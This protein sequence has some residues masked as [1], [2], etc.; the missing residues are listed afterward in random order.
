MDRKQI[1][2]DAKDAIRGSNWVMFSVAQ[3]IWGF[4]LGLIMVVFGILFGVVGGVADAIGIPIV[5]GILYFVI[6]VFGLILML[7]FIGTI[8][9]ASF[10][11]AL[12]LWSGMS[13]DLFQISKYTK[14]IVTNA[15]CM[16]SLIWRMYIPVPFLNIYL[17]VRCYLNTAVKADNPYMKARFC[18]KR[19]KELMKGHVLDLIILILSFF[20]WFLLG[21]VTCGLAMFYVAPYICV[22]IAGFYET[23]KEEQE[24]EGNP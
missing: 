12:D 23:I 24:Y 5:S 16:W 22:S 13:V 14:Y 19:S 17:F 4:I 7:G 15:G 21:M 10:K 20:P 11:N 8:M 3:I 18:A 6:G 1:K 2:T 9:V